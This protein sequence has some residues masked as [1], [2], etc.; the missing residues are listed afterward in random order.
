MIRTSETHPLQIDAMPVANGCLGLTLA[1]GKCC[2]SAIG[3]DW[4]RDMTADV[5][6]IRR[7]G[8]D[9]VVSLTTA[10]EM[11]MMGIADLGAAL[12]RQGIDWL[13]LGFADCHAPDADW[14]TRWRLHAARIHALLE[15]GGRVVIHCRAG[16]ERTATV[17]ALIL[18]ERGAALPEA[19]DRI[20]TVRTGAAPLPGQRAALSRH[21][22]ALQGRAARIRASLLGGAIGDA[23]GAEIEFW[24]LDRIRR[25]FGGDQFSA[26]PHDGQ[27]GSITDDTQMTL[28]TAEGLIRARRRA[29]ERGICDPASVV[30]HAL[31]RWYVTQGEAPRMPVDIRHG[32]ILD[33]R[34]SVRRAPG[35][36]CLSGLGSATRF[37]DAAR[38]DSKG[39]GTIMRMAPVAFLGGSDPHAL[40]IECSALT[41]GHLTAGA[42][43]AAFVDILMALDAGMTVE[44]A[45]REALARSRGETARALG[46]A[47]R[48][49]RDRRP[50][51]IESLGGGWTAE[52]ALAIAVHA[53]LVAEDF[54]QGIR[55]AVSHSGDSDSTG[56]IAGNILGLMYPDQVCRHPLADKIECADRIAWIAEDLA[57]FSAPAEVS[58]KVPAEDLNQ[59]Y[60]GF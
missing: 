3:A 12:E 47:L 36:T 57:R 32:L 40:A 50:E 22:P 37:G 16:L 7:W 42:A 56:A 10:P 19:L 31:L 6:A 55:I 59:I 27:L 58:A 35:L 9:M 5:A 23:T 48:A 49:P 45:G 43:A 15:R 1:P 13:P 41:H 18:V 17:A 28:F 8:A 53:A 52:E 11:R 4:R 24:T 44:E 46:Q 38:N 51:T 30:H 33:P 25:R 60:P 14:W 26:L 20:A 29:L 34:L 54:A 21:A 2:A 39:C